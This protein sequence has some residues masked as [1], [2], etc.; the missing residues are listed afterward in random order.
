MSSADGTRHEGSDSP[1]PRR[2]GMDALLPQFDEAWASIIMNGGDS[3]SETDSGYDPLSPGYLSEMPP[4]PSPE[5]SSCSSLPS[6]PNVSELPNALS[7]TTNL[8]DAD[9]LDLETLD[10]DALDNLD[11]LFPSPPTPPSSSKPPSP[12]NLTPFI[13]SMDNAGDDSLDLTEALSSLEE[14]GA[15]HNVPDFLQMSEIHS[16]K[17]IHEQKFCHSPPVGTLPPLELMPS[18]VMPHLATDLAP[19]AIDLSLPSAG[20][21]LLDMSLPEMALHPSFG[22]DLPSDMTW[23]APRS[24]EVGGGGGLF[25][26]LLEDEVEEPPKVVNVFLTGHDYTNKVEGASCPPQFIPCPTRSV[27]SLMNGGCQQGQHPTPMGV[28]SRRGEVPPPQPPPPPPPPRH[29]NA[30]DDERMFQCTYA[31]CGKVYAKSSH[32]KAH[33]RRHTGEKPFV[34]TWPG[35]SWRFSRSDELARHRRS[36]SGVKPYRCKVCDKRFSRSDHLAKHHKVHRRDRVLALYGPLSTALP[37]R[38]PRMPHY[39]NPAPPQPPLQT[40]PQNQNITLDHTH[41]PLPPIVHTVDFRNVKPI[42]VCQ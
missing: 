35:C 36:H 2:P 24:D 27:T 19:A 1:R 38:R 18:A 20:L 26:Q 37:G 17:V 11:Y 10:L 42:R 39:H 34:C 40:H 13:T 4:T 3:G 23:V 16:P 21:P 14:L 30:R 22:I 29:E 31:G 41:Q 15:T 9:V 7:P 32:L 8:P 33:L 5:A 25:S 28:I 12:V 6:P